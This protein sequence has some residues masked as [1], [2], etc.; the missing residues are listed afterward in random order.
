[1]NMRPFKIAPMERDAMMTDILALVEP[2]PKTCRELAESLGREPKTVYGVLMHM[3][4]TLGVIGPAEKDLTMRGKSVWWE[5]RRDPEPK[6]W[7][8]GARQIVTSDWRRGE[9]HRDAWD[10]ALF[11]DRRVA[12]MPVEVAPRQ[13]DLLEG[14]D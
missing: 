10:V 2:S 13:M 11:G 5:R 7:A 12:G 4:Q 1:M 8:G 14:L 6:G 3:Y 9:H